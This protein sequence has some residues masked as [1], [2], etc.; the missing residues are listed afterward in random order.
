MEIG[1]ETLLS[2][3]GL[4]LLALAAALLLALAWVVWGLAIHPLDQPLVQWVMSQLEAAPAAL[5]GNMDGRHF[6]MAVA[7][8]IL[9]LAYLFIGAMVLGALASVFRALTSA[10]VG[11]LKLARR[12][13]EK[14]GD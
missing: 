10:G 9:V 7:R 11:L 6:E 12:P 13:H 5:T 2:A 14:S 8:P 1:R 4:A 3:I